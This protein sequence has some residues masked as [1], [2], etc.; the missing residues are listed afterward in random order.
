MQVDQAPSRERVLVEQVNDLTKQYGIGYKLS[1]GAVGVL[2]NDRTTI[3][4]DRRGLWYATKSGPINKLTDSEKERLAKK[5]S[6]LKI[7]KQHY[8]KK[9]KRTE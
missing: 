4:E 3:L 2:L 6:I 1:N 8:D 9:A 7:F 5:V